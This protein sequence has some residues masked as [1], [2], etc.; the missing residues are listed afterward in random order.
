[1]LT[2]ED[3][4]KQFH[5]GFG[6]ETARILMERAPDDFKEITPLFPGVRVEWYDED[7]AEYLQGEITQTDS[8]ISGDWLTVE[9]DEGKE[10]CVNAYNAEPCEDDKEEIPA[11]FYATEESALQSFLGKESGQKAAIEAGFRVWETPD[12]Y[13][14]SR[15][16]TDSECNESA[17]MDFYKLYLER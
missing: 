8:G 13:Q 16:C 10:Y 12:D 9:T 1:M 15:D 17:F 11:Y 5:Y 4:R 7:S 6:Y 2:F 14:I 3:F